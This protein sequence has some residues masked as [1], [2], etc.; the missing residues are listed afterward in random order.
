M[1]GL[2]LRLWEGW[3]AFG[4]YLGDFQSRLLLTIFY[5]TV[6]LP[7]G[8]LMRL[9]GDPLRIRPATTDLRSAWMP[10]RREETTLGRARQTF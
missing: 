2:L 6:L 10:R 9:A 3:K 4:H 1:R 5:F 7:Y 8:L